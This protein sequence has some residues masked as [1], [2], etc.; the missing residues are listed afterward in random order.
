M[1]K[2]SNEIQII[3]D[4]NVKNNTD[5]KCLT[6]SIVGSL[7]IEM[8]VTEFFD[9]SIWQFYDNWADFKL[10]SLVEICLHRMLT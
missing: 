4:I 7:V 1:S 3:F 6:V 8:A 5:I 2:A 9:T 10:Q